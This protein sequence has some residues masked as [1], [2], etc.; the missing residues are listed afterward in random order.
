MRE[1]DENNNNW[2]VM[3][4]EEINIGTRIQYHIFI[5]YRWK[6]IFLQKFLRFEGQ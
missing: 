2:A 1:W 3:I 5:T 4:S 6:L